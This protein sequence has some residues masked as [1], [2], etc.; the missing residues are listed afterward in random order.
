M[1]PLHV[2]TV[3]QVSEIAPFTDSLRR[4]NFAYASHLPVGYVMKAALAAQEKGDPKKSHPS[5]L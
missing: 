4:A 3:D 1:G 5:S 2:P